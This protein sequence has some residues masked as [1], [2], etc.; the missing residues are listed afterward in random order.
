MDSEV[1]TR[2]N[3]DTESLSFDV[4]D[5]LLERVANAKQSA[6]AARHT[7][8]VEIGAKLINGPF[9]AVAPA[10]PYSLRWNGGVETIGFMR[11]GTEKPWKS[12]KR[13]GTRQRPGCEG[14]L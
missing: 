4:L 12:G 3:T 9:S 8:R 11:V 5:E 13:C 10:W 6:A 7:L 14:G 1:I 2:T